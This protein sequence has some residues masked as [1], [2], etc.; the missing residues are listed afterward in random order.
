MKLDGRFRCEPSDRHACAINWALHNAVKTKWVLLVDDDVLFF[1][2]IKK[3]LD[4]DPD[5]DALGEI[6]WDGIAGDRLLPYF[7]L[8]NVD[9]MKT[10]KIQYW[11]G[12][13]CAASK[14]P[15]DTGYS[16]RT[17]IQAAGWNIRRIRLN[18]YVAHMKNAS[19]KNLDVRGWLEQYRYL[20]SD[21]RAPGKILVATA[22]T[23]GYDPLNDPLVVT[24]DCDY[25]CVT[26]DPKIRSHVW[27][28]MP[29]PKSA[30]NYPPVRRSK[31]VKTHLYSMFPE[32][33]T[34]FWIDGSITIRGDL[35]K[36]VESTYED[37]KFLYPMRHWGWDDVYEE[38]RQMHV[39]R[40]HRVGGMDDQVARYAR[41]GLPEHHGGMCEGGIR[42]EID[43]GY[44]SE[45]MAKWWKEICL[46]CSRD[47][48]S[49][50]YVLWKLDPGHKGV[51]WLPSALYNDARFFSISADHHRK[52]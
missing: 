47:Q 34:R 1:P 35:K 33:K 37:G 41:D 50:P 26:D 2:T 6:G 14:P 3:L 29:F 4:E 31:Y 40:P 36:L 51:H 9:K 15:V 30:P 7:C 13:P 21:A 10:Q 8:F 39:R 23:R 16:F 17:D 20:W 52:K 32:Y 48:I 43:S 18:G 46:G 19:L 25:V 38:A 24:D 28:T 45:F 5:Y 49:S 42:Y 44:V 11:H 22:I 27:K 12:D